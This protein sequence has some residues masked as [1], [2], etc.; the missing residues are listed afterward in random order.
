MAEDG[1][2]ALFLSLVLLGRLR[3]YIPLSRVS[4]KETHFEEI[5]YLLGRNMS[6][7]ESRIK[8][9]AGSDN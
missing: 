9:D 1:T 7:K 8:S 6:I 2:V 3:R 4:T 5:E